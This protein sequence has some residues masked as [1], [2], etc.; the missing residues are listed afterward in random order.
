MDGFDI[1]LIVAG[2]VALALGWVL[3][4]AAF[5]GT[6]AVLG[7]ASEQGFIGIAA[8]AACWIFIFPVM[9]VFCI[10][11]GFVVKLAD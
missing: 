6:L 11:V 3:L 2:L 5:Y 1:A 9:L 4:R 8:F 7:W 10:I